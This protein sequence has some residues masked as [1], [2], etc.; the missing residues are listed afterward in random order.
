[1][2]DIASGGGAGHRGMGGNSP[3][4]WIEGVLRFLWQ[5]YLLIGCPIGRGLQECLYGF[6][7]VHLASPAPVHVEQD[8]HV[9][10]AAFNLGNKRLSHL[11]GSGQVVLCHPGGLSHGPEVVLK[12]VVAGMMH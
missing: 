3:R 1:M 4:I 7:R 8:I 2:Q 12:E 9:P 10:L 6:A 5:N 11:E